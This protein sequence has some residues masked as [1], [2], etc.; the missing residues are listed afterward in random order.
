MSD[1]KIKID[2]HV[3]SN[4]SYDCLTTI[5]EFRAFLNS[6]KVDKIAITDH[7]RI[8]I[9]FKLKEE[10]GNRIIIG[11]EIMTTHG[12]IIGLFLKK[13]IP[14]NLSPENTIE[15]IRKQKGIVYIPH[16]FDRRRAG[17]GK[18]KKYVEILKSAD[19]IETFNSRCFS[20]IPNLLASKFASQNSKIESVGSDAHNISEIGRSYL[21]MDDFSDE[22]EFM[23]NI[24]SAALVKRKMR[25]R[26]IF[27]PS[28]YRIIKKIKNAY[29]N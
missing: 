6:N 29:Q 23:E 20:N 5:E 15:E 12:E 25:L 18:Y 28:I 22:I 19:I 13:E 27:A 1:K 9:A 11:E 2:L 3:H 21:I 17:I 26:Y 24:Q 4:S 10:F 14:R 8:D 16:P 7:S